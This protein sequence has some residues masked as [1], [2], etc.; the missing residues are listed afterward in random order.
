MECFN[1]FAVEFGQLEEKLINALF[2]CPAV[3]LK[4]MVILVC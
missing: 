4:S 2:L 3:R 1:L